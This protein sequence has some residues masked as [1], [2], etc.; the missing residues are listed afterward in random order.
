[1]RK[2]VASGRER[3]EMVL[4]RRAQDELLPHYVAEHLPFGLAGLV[5]AAFL[6]AAMSAIDS[7]IHAI[8]TLA[9]T[10]FHQRLGMGRAW[11]ARRAG[12]SETAIDEADEVRFARSL[13][14]VIGVSVT[15]ISLVIAHIGDVFAVMSG[16]V[17]ALG[18][19]LLAVFLLGILSRRT[20]ARAACWTLVLGTVFTGW[21]VAVH[22]FPSLAG[23]WPWHQKLQSV[24]LL[25]IGTVA[26][27][28]GGYLLSLVLGRPKGRQDLRGLVVGC[29][30][31][32]VRKPEFAS[33]A[34]PDSFEQTEENG[35][36]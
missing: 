28:A 26:A 12:K 14:L 27:F 7:G 36:S 21:L 3:G 30:T 6:A 34:I 10:D 31:L 24:W 16:I 2:P 18:A 1:M 25:P 19:P 20:T 4:N 17:T 8:C 13:V 33:I 5:F 35:R 23:L 22:Q 15:L 9:I 11:L 29:G 32:G